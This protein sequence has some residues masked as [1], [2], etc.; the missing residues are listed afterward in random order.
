MVAAYYTRI[1]IPRLAELLDLPED[2]TEVVLCK[3]VVAKTVYARI[4]RLAGVVIFDAKKSSDDV[5]N[6]W[7]GNLEKMVGSSFLCF[8]S[9]LAFGWELMLL[10]VVCDGS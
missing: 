2:R 1:T 8:L 9:A 7:S 10:F 4:D 6:D 5:L 3:L